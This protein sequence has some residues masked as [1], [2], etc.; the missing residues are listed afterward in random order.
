MTTSI[1]FRAWFL[2]LRPK[3]LTA[4]I[5]PVVVGTALVVHEHRAIQWWVSAC[6]LLSAIFIQIATNFLND[7]IDFKKGADT[8][9]RTGPQRATQSGLLTAEQV[10]RGGFICLA[11]AFAFGVPLVAVGGWP[12]VIVGLISLALAYGYTGG[13]LPLAYHGLGDLFVILFFGL[14]AVGG[15]YFL[16]THE[17]SWPAI[18]AGLQIGALATVLIAVNNLRDSPQDRL[19]G[20]RTLAV[21]FGVTFARVEILLLCLLPLACGYYWQSHGAW[22]AMLLPFLSL[23]LS[24]RIVVGVFQNEPSPVYNRFLAMSGALLL[25]FGVLLSVGLCWN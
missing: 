7:A 6:A 22:N 11:I 16:H 1:G 25:I 9:T 10:M 5:V 24:R 15:T 14:I 12:I 20:K 23:P 8:E 17:L 18:V 4:A 2:A 13:P 19:V 21:R 3:T